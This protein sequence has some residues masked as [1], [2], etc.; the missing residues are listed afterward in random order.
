M[1]QK[2]LDAAGELLRFAVTPLRSRSLETGSVAIQS[3]GARLISVVP[4]GCLR[5]ADQRH[6]HVTFHELHDKLDLDL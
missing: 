4:A 5:D 3:V 2:T 1:D 6:N